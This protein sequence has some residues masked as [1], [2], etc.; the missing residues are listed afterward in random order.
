MVC[1]SRLGVYLKTVEEANEMEGN[2]P[3]W[4]GD[5][6]AREAWDGVCRLR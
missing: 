1:R 4:G 5:G 2:E 3:L 6:R